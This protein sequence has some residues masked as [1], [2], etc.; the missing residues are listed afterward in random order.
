M[1]EITVRPRVPEDDRRIAEIISRINPDLPPMTVDDY[2]HRVA[3]TPPHVHCERAV[4]EIDGAVVGSSLIL[5]MFWLKEGGGYLTFVAV[6]PD[7][8]GRGIGSRLYHRLMERAAD[9]GANRLYAWFRENQPDA[10]RF[11]TRRG[12]Q[13]TGH[14][15]RTSRLEIRS[16]NLAGYEGLEE[17]LRTEGIRVATLAELGAKD[18]ALLHRLYELHQE[19]VQDIPATEPFGGVPYEPWR[20]DLLEQPGV[21]PQAFWIALAGERPV[22]L[23]LLKREG[24]RA[25][26]NAYTGVARAYRGK[27]VARALKL[28][29]VEWARR[30]GVDFIYTDN[31]VDNKRMLEVNIRLG[32]QPLPGEVQVVKH[33]S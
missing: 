26:Y 17:R 32:Y 19:T 23:A 1:P 20:R 9:F 27:G 2:R 33:L 30:S 11:A 31:D 13:P 22:G 29:T 24:E 15:D 4:A 21:S 16:A 25:A 8:K 12:F 3:T 18:E 14:A 28:R 10:E 7:Y 5:S 6:D